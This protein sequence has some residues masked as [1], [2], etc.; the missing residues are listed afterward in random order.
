MAHPDDAFG[1]QAADGRSAVQRAA[2]GLDPLQRQAEAGGEWSAQW[3]GSPRQ[4]AQRRMI[5]SA[6]GGAAQL[7]E[8][9]AAPNLTGMPD[10]LKSGLE[11]MSGMDLSDVRVHTNS[12]QPAQL[13]ALAYAQ[14]NDI[15]LAPGQEQ[16]LPHEA[17]HVVQQR[18]GRVAPTM[19]V[20]GVP[21]N[22]DHSLESEADR[23]GD[24][25]SRGPAG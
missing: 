14:G 24:M 6:F 1:H 12:S 5:E 9:P 25:A 16:H 23:M 17:W 18:Q 21:V 8:A 13:N 4:A 22:D 7:E 20:G 15:H 11:S 2:A 10:S 3:D 19:E